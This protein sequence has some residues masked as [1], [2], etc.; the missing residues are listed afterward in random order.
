MSAHRSRAA[1]SA[2]PRGCATIW[3]IR[4]SVTG[5]T[6][7]SSSLPRSSRLP[8]SGSDGLA[9]AARKSGLAET[10][11][12]NRN[13]PSSRSS[14]PSFASAAR[15]SASTASCSIASD[16]SPE[17]AQWPSA[18]A[19]TRASARPVIFPCN[20]A[21]T[22]A[23]FSA[24][25]LPGSDSARRS[26]CSVSSSPTTA[27]S[28]LA[29]LVATVA[30]VTWS[31]DSRSESSAN[32]ALLTPRMRTRLPGVLRR[33]LPN[34]AW[35]Q[36]PGSWRAA[37]ALHLLQLVEEPVHHPALPH[38]LGERLA[39]D[40][41]GQLGGQRPDLGAQRGQRLLAFGLDLG[42]RGLGHPARLGLGL[43]AH[44]GDDLRAL[45]PGLLAQPGGLVPGVGQ[46]LPVLLEQL[47]GLLLRLIGA[48]QPALDRLGPLGQYLLDA[49]QPQLGQ[50][51]EH[52]GEQDRA[53]DELRPRGE[54]RVRRRRAV[55]EKDHHAPFLDRAQ[56]Y[57]KMNG[58]TRPISA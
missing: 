36:P 6:L 15:T 7:P 48:G 55:S 27:N 56:L 31:A 47:L 53:D 34:G 21:A 39:H 41:A 32:E 49:G 2:R 40:L 9:S 10:T 5:V 19:A 8:C 11:R 43:L 51:A 54:Q 26:P 18:A 46:L 12:P 28:S 52:Q 44:I 1:V 30:L 17:V 50:E 29:S 35:C 4:L 38:G 58:A 57:L 33:F 13:S 3:L 16:R 37:R 23:P 14:R 20:S 22:T 42:L 45:L 25:G 24:A